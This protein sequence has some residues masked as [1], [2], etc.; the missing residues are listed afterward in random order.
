MAERIAAINQLLVSGHNFE[1]K[2]S[3]E[4]QN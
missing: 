4:K 1:R 2:I 3:I